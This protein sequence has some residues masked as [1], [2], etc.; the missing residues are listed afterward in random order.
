MRGQ[1]GVPVRRDLGHGGGPARLPRARAGATRPRAAGGAVADGARDPAAR[2]RW[3]IGALVA[4]ALG[5][6][7]RPARSRCR[8]H[9]E[10]A[11]NPDSRVTLSARRDALGDAAPQGRLAADRTGSADGRVMVRAWRRRVPAARPGR[12]CAREPGCGAP[13]GQAHVTDSYHHMG[14]TRMGTEPADER[15]GRE[16]RVHG[17]DGLFVA[18]SSVFPAAGFANPTLPIAT[19]ADQAGRPPQACDWARPHRPQPRRCRA[20]SS[21]SRRT[22]SRC[23]WD[24]HA[25]PHPERADTRYFGAAFIEMESRSSRTGRSTSTSPGTASG[26]RTTGSRRG[27]V[28]LGDEVG[29]DPALRRTRRGRPSR[30]T[31]TVRCWARVRCGTRA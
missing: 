10:Q 6:G 14:T 24:P 7:C 3:P 15:R 22:R 16:G 20:T 31:G 17:V 1:P 19:L 30:G 23:R 13:A 18:G 21:T 29:R 8:L 28:L 25:G 12:A 4:R 11:P 27:G 2:R 5:A 26:C 9:A